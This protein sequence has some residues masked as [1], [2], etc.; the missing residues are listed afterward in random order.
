MAKFSFR[1]FLGVP[2]LTAGR[3][4]PGSASLRSLRDSASG[5]PSIPLT[6]SAR[7]QRPRPTST[8]V[9]AF[10]FP[11]SPPRQEGVASC[12]QFFRRLQAADLR[13]LRNLLTKSMGFSDMGAA[14]AA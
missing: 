13:G 8:L 14:P 3:V 6:Q 5:R 7:G 11:P 9:M 12:D 4:P 10:A 1:D 2:G